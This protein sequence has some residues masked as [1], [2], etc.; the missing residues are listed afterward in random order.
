MNAGQLQ[1]KVINDL[2]AGGYWCTRVHSTRGGEPDMIA[3]IDGLYVGIEVKV[4]KD[5]MTQLQEWKKA[6]I[7]RS[8]GLFWIVKDYEGYKELLNRIK[9]VGDDGGA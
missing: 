4:G 3:C 9:G 5:R 2:I 8:G 6:R 7:E 1:T